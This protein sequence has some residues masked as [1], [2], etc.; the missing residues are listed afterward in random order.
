MSE[1]PG[2]DDRTTDALEALIAKERWIE[3]TIQTIL[4]TRQLKIGH[5]NPELVRDGVR[6]ASL[7]LEGFNNRLITTPP[8]SDDG[9]R[10][11]LTASRHAAFAQSETNHRYPNGMP[12]LQ[13][14]IAAHDAFCLGFDE[15]AIWASRLLEWPMDDYGIYPPEPTRE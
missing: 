14:T 4:A 5:M 11:T 8:T 6:I 9:L 13:L 2:Y 3:T 15:D 12:S 1:I 7:W 10:E